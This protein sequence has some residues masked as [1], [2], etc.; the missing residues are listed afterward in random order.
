MRLL[1]TA[2]IVLFSSSI[3]LG[4]TSTK[5]IKT[6]TISYKSGK[7]TFQCYEDP[8][9]SNLIKHGTF[10]FSENLKGEFGSQIATITGHFKDGYRDG[11]WSYTIKK[12][13]AENLNGTYTTGTFT[14][15]QN[16]NNGYPNGAWKLD[17]TW[18]ARGRIMV[19]FKYIWSSYSVSEKESASFSFKNGMMV[20]L[21]NFTAEGKQKTIN[22]NQDGFVTGTI[23]EENIGTT[24]ERN[25]NSKGVITKY[26]ERGSASGNVLNFIDFDAELLQVADDYL[27]NRKSLT[28]LK[29]LS[30]KLDTLQGIADVAGFMFD[31]DYFYLPG[32]DGDKTITRNGNERIHGKGLQFERIKFIPYKEHSRWPTKNSDYYNTKAQIKSYNDFLT[33]YGSEISKQDYGTI[34]QLIKEAENELISEA[35]L[36]AAQKQYVALYSKLNE[37][38]KVKPKASRI[39]GIEP[40]S[41]T[42]HVFSRNTKSTLSKYAV[43]ATNLYFACK[44]SK[45]D[46]ARQG[47]KWNE[48]DYVASLKLL[49]EYS[50][51]LNKKQT[52]IDSLSTL[53][54]WI[55]EIIFNEN[56]I[57]CK[58]IINQSNDSFNT[59]SAA[60]PR[61]TEKPKLY[62]P[63]LNVFENIL[64]ETGSLNTFSD[65]YKN[66]KSLN[67]L[68]WFMTIAL[69]YKTSNMEKELKT[70]VDYKTQFAIFEKAIYSA[71]Y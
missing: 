10:N 14:S 21:V 20:G 3:C 7:A 24:T 18:K 5:I 52:T 17:N 34:Q 26:V 66:I 13:D 9:T 11:L 4:Q 31:D 47:Y 67:D 16:F 44:Y 58:Y 48:N 28:D 35:N 29:E 64:R 38:L 55:N 56:E 19:D 60:S 12:I 41:V 36:E 42:T 30:I 53:V 33:F 45:N 61:Q 51:F 71:I 59:Y 57:E 39:D 8:N 69:N 68:C 22:L 25:F 40:F 49:Q 23:I 65:Y 54:A 63:Y 27:S 46:F 50:S 6:E 32:I 1:K 15:I 2:L 43:N 70:T 62:V 37:K